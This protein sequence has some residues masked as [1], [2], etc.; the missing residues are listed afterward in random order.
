[1]SLDSQVFFVIKVFLVSAV[2]SIFIKY[3]LGN[4]QLIDKTYLALPI[5]LTPTILVV[6]TLVS[7]V[8]SID[9]QS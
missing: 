2:I 8:L 7:R 9:K 4:F 3:V 5:V 1:M 6:I